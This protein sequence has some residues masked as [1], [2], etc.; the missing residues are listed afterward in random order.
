VLEGRDTHALCAG[1]LWNTASHSVCW[2]VVILTLVSVCCFAQCALEGCGIVTLISACC[3]APLATLLH[4]SFTSFHSACVLE[5]L[6]GC[7]FAQ[8]TLE[9]CGMLLRTVCAADGWNAASHSVCWKVVEY[10]FAQCV[11]AGCG[12]LCWQVV[13]CGTVTFIS[14][15]CCF[16]QCV[17]LT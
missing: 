8:C 14:V 17:L 7:C 9:G 5:V 11:L 6:M 12:M 2:K 13:L 3:F 4:C 10:G 16:T 15:C 1:R